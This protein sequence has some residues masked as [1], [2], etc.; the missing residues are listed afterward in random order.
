MI[1]AYPDDAD[2]DA[3]RW[4][5]GGGSD[6]SRPMTID[7]SVAAPNRATAARVAELVIAHGF[8]PSISQD[9]GATTWSVYCAKSMLATYDGVVEGQALLNSLLQSIGANCDG[10]GTLGNSSMQ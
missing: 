5:A 9:E 1:N 4:V 10:W 2:G 6:M 7:F 8:A 3:L